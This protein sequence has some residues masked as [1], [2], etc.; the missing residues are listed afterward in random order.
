M[1]GL[2]DIQLKHD[3]VRVGTVADGIGLYRFQYNWSDQVYVGVM[4][5]EVQA[6]RP[7]AVMR[8][9]D[10][11]LRVDYG[12]IGVHFQTWGQWMA[13]GGQATNR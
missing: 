12:R 6:V 9:R 3:V 8:G 5:Q 1:G 11:Y 10:G 7:D 2:S 13:S 4:A